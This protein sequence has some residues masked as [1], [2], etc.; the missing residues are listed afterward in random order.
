MPPFERPDPAFAGHLLAE[1]GELF[2]QLSRLRAAMDDEAPPGCQRLREILAA[3]RGL[4]GRLAGHFRQEEEGGLLEESVARIPRLAADAA[5]V[6]AEHPRL[7]ADL[8][9]ITA[10]FGAADDAPCADAWRGA[11]AAFAAFVERMQAHER[12]ENDVVQ[13]GYN[14][15]LGIDD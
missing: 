1:H 11:R 10:R 7:L 4:R 9:A 2:Q 6:L 15:D 5:L 13:Q 3:I 14:E 8:D 12:A